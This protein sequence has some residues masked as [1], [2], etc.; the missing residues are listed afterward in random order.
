VS[1][2]ASE[3]YSSS[4]FHQRLSFLLSRCRLRKYSVHCVYSNNFISTVAG[5]LP[6]Q[7]TGGLIQVIPVY[8]LCGTQL[9]FLRDPATGK[10]FYVGTFVWGCPHTIVNIETRYRQRMLELFE[11]FK[12]WP[13]EDESDCVLVVFRFKNEAVSVTMPKVCRVAYRPCQ[14]SRDT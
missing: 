14:S 5:E 11:L 3:T 8:V 7:P 12:T 2:E 6:G 9:A 13:S 1:E 4:D 10:L